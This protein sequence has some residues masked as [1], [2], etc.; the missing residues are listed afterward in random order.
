LGIGND[1][2]AH[3]RLAKGKQE[4]TI[5]GALKA[6]DRIE[7]S[8]SAP[9]NHS[10]SSRRRFSLKSFSASAPRAGPNV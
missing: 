3:L 7:R 2:I 5:D 10:I 4:A 9:S 6:I 8:A 1:Y